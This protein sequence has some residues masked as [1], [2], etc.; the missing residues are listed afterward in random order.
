[1]QQVSSTLLCIDKALTRPNHSMDY[2]SCR[3]TLTQHQ[4]IG[5]S[6]AEL[7]ETQLTPTS[8]IDGSF[9]LIRTLEVDEK[10]FAQPLLVSNVSTSSG[11]LDLVFVASM[12]NTLYAFPQNGTDPLWTTSLGT[13]YPY[14]NITGG[15]GQDNNI[16]NLGILGTPVIDKASNRIY[17]VA[18]VTTGPDQY[19]H[20]LHAFDIGTGQA[21][22]GSPVTI[23]AS[24]PGNATWV[25]LLRK[26]RRNR[27]Y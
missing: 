15:S 14:A 12:N 7:C 11:T 21:V 23:I 3:E 16:D 13:S 2:G 27:E 22:T 25:H 9:G 20:Q 6:G 18:A 8:I 4:D 19:A 1:M 17:A 5:R 26:L 10:V 24:T